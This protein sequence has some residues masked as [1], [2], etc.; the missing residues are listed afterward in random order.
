MREKK[1]LPL[2]N[3]LF[4]VFVIL[5]LTVGVAYLVMQPPMGELIYLAELLGITAAVSMVLG[6]FS[7]RFGWWRVFSRISLSLT[8]GYFLA[9]GLTL[10]NV[11]L[12]ARMMFIN[13]HDF[14]LGSLLL[15]FAGGISI[16]FGYFFSAT[17]TRRMEDLET[18]IKQLGE[19]EFPER[20]GA[21]GNDE[22]ARLTGAFNDMNAQLQEAEHSKQKMEKMRRDLI[23]WVSHD[24]RTPL[25]SLSAMVNALRDGVVQDEETVKRYLGQSHEEIQRMGVLINDLFE[26]ARLEAGE[27]EIQSELSSM[28]DLLSD[29]IGSFSA[30]AKAGGVALA[31]EVQAGIDPVWMAAEKI[32]R[33]LNNLVENALRHTP[34][35]GRIEIRGARKAGEVV[36][37]VADSGE[38]IDA[39]EQARIFE[40]FY[41]GGESRSRR[42]KD[43]QGAGLGLTIS[44]GIVE[45]HGG[46]IWVKSAP[47]E[48]TTISF[49]LPPGGNPG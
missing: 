15:V 21:E 31:G 46:R 40:R 47:G 6:Y 27:V 12:T 32:G 3:Y 11:W 14:V 44:K 19:G 22:L 1:P 37:S 9:A 33:V 10:V 16:A 26:L 30:R 5:S 39:E 2:W 4:I 8:A 17:V 24:L 38:G 49:S 7:M 13:E 18:A 20:I 42:G 36:V 45:A 25:A 48:G 35:G 28:S 29:T 41:R 34:E 23:T 43:A